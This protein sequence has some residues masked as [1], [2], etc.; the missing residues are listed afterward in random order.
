MAYRLAL[1]FG[2]WDVDQFLS[3]MPGYVFRRWCEFGELEPFGGFNEE[4][5]FATLQSTMAALRGHK[6]SKPRDFMPKGTLIDEEEETGSG[7]KGFRMALK[8]FLRK[9]GRKV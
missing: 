9:G 5:R 4:L 3:E 8:T 6:N 7:W 1:A 2:R